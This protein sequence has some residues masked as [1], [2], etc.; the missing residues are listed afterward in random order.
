[1][2]RGGMRKYLGAVFMAVV[3]V[4]AVVLSLLAIRAISHEEA[5]VEK[6]LE[7]TL[8]AEVTHTASVVAAEVGAIQSDLAAAAVIPESADFS[9]AFDEW[10]RNSPLVEVPFLL[11]SEH[12]ILWPVASAAGAKKGDSKEAS[13]AAEQ[14]DFF[15][16]VEEIPVYEN[17]AVAFK[18]EILDETVEAEEAVTYGGA[19]PAALERRSD[20]GEAGAGPTGTQPQVTGR[21]ASRAA[22]VSPPGPPGEE[23]RKQAAITEFQQ[24]EEV[25]RKVFDKAE[26]DGQEVLYRNVDLGRTGGAEATDVA[27]TAAEAEVPSGTGRAG[28]KDAPQA[29]RVDHAEAEMSP[30]PTEAA[31]SK[32]EKLAETPA[33]RESANEAPKAAG[34]AGPDRAAAGRIRSVFI[35]QPLSF[36]EIVADRSSGIIPRTIDGRLRHIYWQ[37]LE[38]GDIMGC[39]ID[40]GGFRERLIGA[41]ANIYSAVR[42]LTV[43]DESG[44][45]L[46]VPR[47]Q[48]GRDWREPFVAVEISELLPRW[49][50][51]AYL[52]EADAISSRA[53]ATTMV[54]WIL[55]FI[56]FVSIL[57]GGVLVLR[58]AYAEVRLARQRTSFVANVSHELKT[59]LTSIRMY[60]EML[61][62]GRQKDVDKQKH[63]LEIMTAE[64]ERLT[65]LINNVLDFSRIERGEKRYN[66]TRCDLVALT[67]DVVESQRARLEAGGFEVGFTTRAGNLEIDADE[68]AVKQA[69]V[70]LLSNSEKYSPGVKAIEIEVGLEGGRAAVS[71]SD[72]GVGIPSGEVGNIFHEFYRVDDTLT[73]EV[74]GAGL[75]LTIARKIVAD[76]GGDIA[77]AAREG[78]GSTFRI[79]L[80]PAG[81]ARGER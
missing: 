3:M 18:D 37:R 2:A 69:V 39:L 1:M 68:E 4:P 49:E 74:K 46:I 41:L 17:I 76:H 64:A 16:D 43:L 25:R 9:T 6:Q 71:V 40:A 32:M 11:S 22:G 78:G 77:Y 57:A 5:Y 66:M 13:F 52:T 79:L 20:S 10:K 29:A 27:G 61:R 53:R 58:S 73:S 35:S 30:R 14:K 21:E 15:G 54:M 23:S 28:A 56:L 65:R 38:S 72:R 33:G 31:A 62:D 34:P 75:G 44:N 26:K 55:I 59:P 47:G 12:E 7:G 63:Y 51:A 45:P 50:S 19:V 70:N 80:P 42:I 24:S 48:E 8:S 81:E 67:S 36:S 60:A